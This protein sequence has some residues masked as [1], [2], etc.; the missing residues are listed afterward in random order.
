MMQ[1]CGNMS[2]GDEMLAQPTCP[3]FAAERDVTMWVSCKGNAGE[4][5]TKAS[6]SKTAAYGGADNFSQTR[7][8]PHFLKQK[9][10]ITLQLFIYNLAPE[11]HRNLGSTVKSF[12]LSFFIQFLHT[13]MLL[14]MV[15]FCQFLTFLF[16]GIRNKWANIIN[17]HFDENNGFERN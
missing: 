11:S 8:H 5:Q 16:D 17:M 4:V 14:W 13:L 15:L 1:F 6:E 2:S 9:C 10:E 3:H 7:M 12:H